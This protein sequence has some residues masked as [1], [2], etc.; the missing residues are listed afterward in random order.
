MGQLYLVYAERIAESNANGLYEYDLY[1]SETPELVWGS[2]WNASCPSACGLEGIRP[3]E[4][5]YQ[6]IKRLECSIPFNC[7]RENSCFSCQ[8]MI[9][10]IV[11]CMWEDISDYDE[12]PEPFRLVFKFGETLEDII[13]K[14]GERS[15]KFTEF[16]S[17]SQD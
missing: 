7:I 14:L 8:D 16:L 10:Q 15:A 3:D 2:D 1:F 5:T 17:Q 9:D 6:T 13:E 12:Y 11:A 4:S